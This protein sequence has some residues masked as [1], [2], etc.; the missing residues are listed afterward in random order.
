MESS[1]TSGGDDPGAW[2]HLKDLLSQIQERGRVGAC[3]PASCTTPQD[4]LCSAGC[5][6]L[7]DTNGSQHRGSE[8]LLGPPSPPQPPSPLARFHLISGRLGH[9][10][11]LGP[12]RLEAGEL[13]APWGVSGHPTVT[14]S[15]HLNR[16]AAEL[17]SVI[18]MAQNA[19]PLLWDAKSEPPFSARATQTHSWPPEMH[20]PLVSILRRPACS[21]PS[22]SCVSST[23]KLLL[24]QAVPEPHHFLFSLPGITH[25]YSLLVVISSGFHGSS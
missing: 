19:P 21:S 3:L 2:A 12:V 25:C 18:A 9:E 4:T 11:G 14:F 20:W 13:R 22:P 1:K 8:P 6:Q 5:H 15:L 7:Q 16:L 24:V 23:S 10:A 17:T